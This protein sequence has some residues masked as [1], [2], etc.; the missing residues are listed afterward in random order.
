MVER[1]KGQKDQLHVLNINVFIVSYT[2]TVRTCLLQL[3]SALHFYHYSK[4]KLYREQKVH[5]GAYKQEASLL[6]DHYHRNNTQLPSHRSA[7]LLN[8]QLTW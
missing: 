6:S 3:S 8:M 1:V 2:D 5:A 4:E 7:I